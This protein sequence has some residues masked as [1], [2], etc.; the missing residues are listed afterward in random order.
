MR[1][2]KDSGIE[3]FPLI[4]Q[5]WKVGRIKDIIAVLTDY[6]ANGSFGDLAKNVTYLDYEDYAR[7]I[8]LTDLRENLENM[9]VYVDENSYNYLSK[10]S[11]F[12]GEILVANV[13][14]YAGLFCEMPKT[15]IPSTLAPNMFLI[16]TN[17]R[18]LQHYLFYVGNS[19]FVWEQLS[20]KAISSAQPKLNKTDVKTVFL[21][22]PP[23]LEQKAIAD[24][25]DTKCTEIDALV[26]DIQEQIATLEEYKRS[27]ITEA[28]TKGL[29]P[30]VDM[31]DS[32]IEWVGMIPV[33]WSVHPVYTYFG[34]RKNKNRFGM[35]DNLLSLSYGRVIRKNINTSDG[36]LPESFNTYNIVEAGDIIIRPT[37]LQNDK[38]SLRTGLVKEHGIITSAYIDLCPIKKVDSRYF[39][40]LLHAYDVMKVFYNMGNGVRQ[41]LNYSEFSRLMVFEPQYEEQVAIADFLDAKI[42]EVNTIIEQKKEQLEVLDYYKKSLIYEYVTGK[43][44]VSANE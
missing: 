35:E 16:R 28:V 23:C 44:E 21:P 7:L 43:K 30:D 3:W 8:R 18:M 1:E 38:R 29:N 10:S 15:N 4:P 19:K 25:L 32:G 37:D 9:G 24:F 5:H 20:Q 40:F 34:E 42:A 11:L 12:G 27:V 33:H 2:M 36:L 14:A 17:N 6:T 26:S 22:I 31:K 13:G 41:G 39:H